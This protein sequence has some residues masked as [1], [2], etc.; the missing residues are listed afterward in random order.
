MRGRGGGV[1]KSSLRHFAA[2]TPRVPSH[3]MGASTD[4]A[5]TA[6]RCR[7]RPPQVSPSLLY[8]LLVSCRG[9]SSCFSAGRGGDSPPRDERRLETFLYETAGGGTSA[10]DGG[11]AGDAAA[12]PPV[13]VAAAWPLWRGGHEDG[14]RWRGTPSAWRS[15]GGRELNRAWRRPSG[16]RRWVLVL[17]GW[18]RPG[19]RPRPPSR[20]SVEGPRRRMGRRQ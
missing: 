13:D 1:C 8:F 2:G 15:S 6:H 11:A 4:V 19:R 16:A 14:L 3:R 12:L 7:S 20:P 18:P 17:L 5:A 10:C 9:G